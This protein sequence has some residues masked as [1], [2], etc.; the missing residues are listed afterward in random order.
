MKKFQTPEVELIKFAMIDVIATSAVE[1]EEEEGPPP[2]MG[3]G[4]CLD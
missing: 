3:L 1:E 2:T 4:N